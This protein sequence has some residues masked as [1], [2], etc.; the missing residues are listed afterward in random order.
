MSRGT[1]SAVLF[2]IGGKRRNARSRPRLSEKL[3]EDLWKPLENLLKNDKS[4]KLAE[5]ENCHFRLYFKGFCDRA[6]SAV[7]PGLP[8]QFF[9][10]LQLI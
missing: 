3:S 4:W 10:A 7:D 1:F 9:T 5:G 6:R 8:S 2:S